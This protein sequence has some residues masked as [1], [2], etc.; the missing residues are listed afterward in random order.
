MKKILLVLVLLSNLA[1]AQTTGFL[2]NFDDGQMTGWKTDHTRTFQLSIDSTFLKITYTR[3]AQSGPWDNF[4]LT[5]PAEVDVS[6]TPRMY[7]RARA[8]IPVIIGLKPI[9]VNPVD[10]ISNSILGD[11]KWKELFFEITSPTNR[12]VLQV[13]GYFDGGS[14]QQ[15]SG[16]VWFDEIRIGDAVLTLPA[17]FTGLEEALTAANALLNSATEGTGE[18]EFPVGSKTDLQNAIAAAAS[19]PGSNLHQSQVDSVTSELYNMCSIF[20]S[21]VNTLSVNIADKNANKQ[22]RYLYLNLQDLMHRGLLFGMHDATG[23]GVGWTGDDDRSDVKDVCGDFPAIYSEDLNNVTRGSS[24][25]RVRYR[26]TSAHRRGGVIT[27]CW[28]QYDPDGRSFYAADINNE[29]IVSQILPG[30]AR[31]AD[32]LVKLKRVAE[33]FKSLRGDHGEAIP[34]IFR[35]YHEHSGDWFWWGVGHCTTAEYNQLW[36][37][38][39]DYLH[40]TLNVHNLLWAISPSFDHVKNANDYFDRFPGDDYVDIYGTDFYYSDPVP[41]AVVNDFRKGLHTI[42]GHALE[43][44]KIPAITEIGQE[45]LDD[46]DWFT[47]MLINPIR[48][49]SI[50]THLAYAAVWR[51]ESRTHHFAPYPGHPAVPDFLK[52]YNDPFSLFESDLPDMYALPE[53]DLSAPI[54]TAYP[55]APF[56]SPATAVEINI[57]TNER[58]F[59]RWSSVDTDYNRMPNQFQFGERNFIIPLSSTQNRSRKPKSLCARLIF[60]ATKPPNRWKSPFRW[61][62]CRQLLPGTICNIQSATGIRVMLRSGAR[63]RTQ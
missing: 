59:L 25:D 42:V 18:G 61:I 52:F 36:Q 20:E 22:T 41:P 54:F 53:E 16:T 44:N 4:N 47:K 56:V 7:V 37:F 6:N 21:R 11:G 38:T 29:K 58:A 19:V 46:S 62:P 12:R 50:N 5:L 8:D 34:V 40:Q 49:D 27:M 48:D 55:A 30:G 13:Y 33:F 26:L 10:L 17:N 24:I 39:A 63:R 15:K 32:Y 51:N 23:Y 14:S 57:V 43:H 60:M 45:G 3:T 28:H 35:P 2:Q 9:P 1:Q 31:H